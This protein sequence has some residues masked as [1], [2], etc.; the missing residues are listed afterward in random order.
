MAISEI[1]SGTRTTSPVESSYTALYSSSTTT[2]GI[3]CVVMDLT[4]MAVGDIVEIQLLE[5]VLSTGNQKVVFQAIFY[6]V[7]ADP[8]FISP[9]LLLMHGWAFGV[10]QT[11]GSSRSLD[12][13]IRGVTA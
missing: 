11:A 4:N 12:W 7:Q 5:K 6:D 2:D 1:A 10:R 3:F 13:S 8:V 9:S